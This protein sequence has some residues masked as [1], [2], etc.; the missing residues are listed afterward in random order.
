MIHPVVRLSGT[1]RERGT[2]HIRWW[3]WDL[4]CSRIRRSAT[5]PVA[6]ALLLPGAA[7]V[8]VLVFVKYVT[9]IVGAVGRRSPSP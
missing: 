5:L 6:L 9:V 3:V 8:A 4:T 7:L 2:A 1:A